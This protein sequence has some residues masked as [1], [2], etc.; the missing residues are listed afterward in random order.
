MNNREL[1]LAMRKVGKAMLDAH[2]RG[3]MELFNQKREEYRVAREAYTSAW[4]AGDR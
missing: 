1:Y 3:N 2:Q 4:L